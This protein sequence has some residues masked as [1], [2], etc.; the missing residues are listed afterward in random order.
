MQPHDVIEQRYELTELLGRGGFG[1]VWRAFDNRVRRQVA[2]KIGYPRTADEARRLALEAELAG[3]LT[4]PNI[5]AL[6]DYGETSH[7]GRELVYLVMEL[8]T[9]DTLATVIGRGVPPVPSSL[10]WAQDI[11][12][13]LGAAHDNGVVHR[14]IKP[15]NVIVT[16]PGRGTAKVLDFGIARHRAHPGITVEGHVIGSAPYM[17]PE[18]W[19]SGAPVDGRADLYALGCVLTELLT[20]RLPFTGS[21]VHELLAQH[22]AG[23]PPRPSSLRPGL[24][25]AADRLVLDLLAKEPAHRPAHARQVAARLADMIRRAQ[26]PTVDHT[27]PGHPTPPHAP[28]D[29]AYTPTAQ[30]T[31]PGP[32]ADPAVDPTA[33]PVD[34]SDDPVRLA[35]SRRLDEALAHWST[36]DETEFVRRLDPLIRDLVRELGPD[37]PLTVETGYQRAMYSWQTAQNRAG[38]EDMLPRL[39]RNL[40]PGHRRTIDV[41]A[42]LTGDLAARGN[43]D[44]RPFLPELR[45][46]IDRSAQLLGAHDPI[47][48]T[49][50][51][52]LADALDREYVEGRP[53]RGTGVRTDDQAAR[54]R[55]LLEP[56][57]PDLVQGLGADH[58]RVIAT[59]LRLALDTYQLG[60]HRAALPLYE[61][62]LP[63][64]PA[65][66]ARSDVRLRIQHAHCVAEADDPER[67]LALLDTLLHTL[68][69]RPGNDY[70]RQAPPALTLRAALK[71]RIRQD[72]RAA[73]HNTRTWF[74]R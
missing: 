47:T 33:D 9:G 69:N 52:D 26:D 29:P 1:Q 8:V 66:L 7:A 21:E 64:S 62:L 73:N 51:L 45:E 37:D 58:S 74:R 14:D 30:Q 39:I 55:A 11:C 49:A 35:L 72:R 3:N 6:Y 42:V 23:T 10:A 65:A 27:A 16:G 50:R 56:L 46:I 57:L 54:R 41:Q 2:V 38:L 63:T 53:V 67:A 28:A 43:V 12:E 22:I 36:G 5:A 24:P 61:R 40:G 59:T 13:A 71:K 25:E 48:L 4:H 19:N 31:A 18:R 32:T 44:G 17:A 34:R 15:A 20:G 70:A 68:R 60:D